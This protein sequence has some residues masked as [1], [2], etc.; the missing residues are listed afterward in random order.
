MQEKAK[1]LFLKNTK[2]VKVLDK[3]ANFSLEHLHTSILVY[4]ATRRTV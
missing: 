4:L 1:G 2:K 3:C